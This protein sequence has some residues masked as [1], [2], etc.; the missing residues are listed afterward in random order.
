MAECAQPVT[1]LPQIVFVLKKIIFQKETGM[2]GF[3]ET[4]NREKEN[5]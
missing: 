1:S 3:Q 4:L 5:V 2:S